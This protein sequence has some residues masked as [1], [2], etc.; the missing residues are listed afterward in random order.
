MIK[1]LQEKELIDKLKFYEAQINE[2][3]DDFANV[4]LLAFSKR[5]DYIYDVK[6]NKHEDTR[7]PYTQEAAIKLIEISK[8]FEVS[9][10]DI[11]E[12][13][14]DDQNYALEKIQLSYI[15]YHIYLDCFEELADE[16]DLWE[17]YE[18]ALMEDY[19]IIDILSEEGFFVEFDTKIDRNTGLGIAE[20][21]VKYNKNFHE[22]FGHAT[23][24]QQLDARIQNRNGKKLRV[25]SKTEMLNAIKKRLL[26]D[27]NDD[28]IEWSPDDED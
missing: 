9:I 3:N 16:L 1:T 12:K 8:S 27:G 19:S 26:S 13:M 7:N 21:I 10:S 22:E 25:N 23:W 5:H 6:L 2:F 28:F 17:M 24:E 20:I 15:A 4:L 11:V 14:I 18:D